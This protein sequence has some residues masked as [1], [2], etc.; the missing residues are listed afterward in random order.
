MQASER[1]INPEPSY[2]MARS[3][4]DRFGYFPGERLRNVFGMR[5]AGVMDVGILGG[6]NYIYSLCIV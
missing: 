3:L 2:H 5:A 1:M 4:R 6:L